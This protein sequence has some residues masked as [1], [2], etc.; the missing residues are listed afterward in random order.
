[1]LDGARD[2]WPD[3]DPNVAH[4]NHGSYGAVPRPVRLYQD[5][6]RRQAETNPNRWFRFDLPERLE[7]ARLSMAA[8]VGASPDNAVWVPNATTG[9]NVALTA[10]PLDAGAEILITDHVYGAI[11]RT[12]E[13]MAR[14]IGGKVTV[15]P[16][17]LTADADEVIA[18]ILAVVTEDTRVAIVE[19]IASVTGLVLPIQQIVDALQARD[20]V[21]I[22]DAA[23]SPGST[24]LAVD[25][26]GADFWVGN[27]HKW[28]LA[29]RPC[30]ALVVS[31]EW[32]VSTEPLVAS[33]GLEDGLPTSFAW[34]GTDDYSSWLCL[35]SGVELVAGYGWAQVRAHNDALAVR[36]A[37]IVGT[38]LGVSAAL[39]K[40]ARGPMSLLP[41]PAGIAESEN[42]AREFILT[43]SSELGVEVAANPWRG[44]GWL[45][46][47]AHIYNSEADY[48]Q[49]AAGL[50]GL[51]KRLEM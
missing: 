42:T 30:A 44:R 10:V 39:P 41:L 9:V 43:V 31:D 13:R 26:L 40:G 25:G 37:E 19:H 35:D 16:V 21:V 23:H 8:F 45:R 4:C 20:V 34:H 15:A 18:Q 6:L 33:F 12:A 36:A 51:L 3:L 50:P 17:D 48:E 22:V 1:M 32:R 29:P 11:R 38:A 27:F 7:S 24:P 46:L 28:T 47:S 14:R 2:L 5:E 49:L